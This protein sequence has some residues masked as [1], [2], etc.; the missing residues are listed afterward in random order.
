[1]A[2]TY[3]NAQVARVKDGLERLCTHHAT[4]DD[5]RSVLFDLV[6]ALNEVER[7]EAR[8]ET[9]VRERGEAA[10][11]LDA[12]E[13]HLVLPQSWSMALLAEVYEAGGPRELLEGRRERVRALIREKISRLREA[14]QTTCA[15]GVEPYRRLMLLYEAAWAREDEGRL[16]GTPTAA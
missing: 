5:W 11:A 16:Q 10:L 4:D 1:M 7:I 15:E 6:K 13:G 3:E 12:I 8:V 2:W 14:I 9:L